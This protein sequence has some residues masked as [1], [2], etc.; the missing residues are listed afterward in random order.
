MLNWQNKAVAAILIL[1]VGIVFLDIMGVLVKL[2]MPRF[3]A[4]ELSVYRNLIGMLPSLALLF[5]TGDFKFT[6]KALILRQWPLALLRG[7]FVAI[8]QLFFYVALGAMKFAAVST[9]VYSMS[10]FSV[11]FSVPVLLAK[12]GLLRWC[13]V[14]IG[15]VGVILVIGPGSGTFTLIAL[16]PLAAAALYALASITMRL[17]DTNA[18]NSLIYLYSS[19]SAVIGAVILALMTTRFSPIT[20]WTD[21]C[22]IICLGLS[23]GIGVLLLMVAY[24]MAMPSVLAPFNYFGILSAFTLGW[25]ILGEA[26]FDQLFPGVIFIIAGGLMVIWREAKS[27]TISPNY[28]K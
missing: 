17:F 3:G 11:V 19:F 24:R 10:L 20:S 12:V 4:S 9:I 15:F 22:L 21:L 16:L 7:G 1:L 8:A 18:L 26:P 5:W 6:K 23:G 28:D 13:A 14:I 25:L 27:N 2:L